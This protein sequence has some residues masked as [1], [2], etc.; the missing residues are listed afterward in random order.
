[1]GGEVE[2]VAA[3]W[4]QRGIG[5]SS[6]YYTETVA[7][8]PP[9]TSNESTREKKCLGRAGGGNAGELEGII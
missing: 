6:G 7:I 4:D 1:M 2:R 5:S 8:T 9:S 3:G